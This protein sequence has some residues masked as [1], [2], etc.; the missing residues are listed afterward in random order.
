MLQ[1]QKTLAN[2]LVLQ[3]D[4]LEKAAKISQLA[5][6]AIADKAKGLFEA[7]ILPIIVLTGGIIIWRSVLPNPSAFQLIGLG[8]YGICLVAPVFLWRK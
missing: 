5:A 4:K 3:S 1:N 8:L 7:L 2:E 6:Y